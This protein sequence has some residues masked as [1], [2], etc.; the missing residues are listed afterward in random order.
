MMRARH[1][2]LSFSVTLA[3]CGSDRFLLDS[4]DPGVDV[5]TDPGFDVSRDN[6]SDAVDVTDAGN[7]SGLDLVDVAMD[8]GT[9]VLDVATDVSDVRVDAVGDAGP[10][11][12]CLPVIDGV[13]GSDWTASA[14]VAD[15]TVAT[16]WGVGM[17]DLRS[18]RVCYDST[19]LYLGIDGDAQ[20][21]N[22]VVAYIDRDYNPPGGAPTGVSIFSALTDH[23][24]ALDTRISAALMLGAGAGNFGAEA[25][26]GTNG[27]LSLAGTAVSDNAGLRLISQ[28]TS[29]LPDGGALPD[30]RADFAWTMGA[31]SA[32]TTTAPFAC[33]VSIA[34]AS[35]YEGPRPASGRIALFLRINNSD[36]T[37]TSNQTIPQDDPTMPRVVNRVLV[38]SFAP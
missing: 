6:G 26:W 14:I 25:A 16:A 18:L 23:A 24:G 32:C 38:L 37:M 10:S 30:R 9:D 36:G 33:E 12:R 2:L 7:D 1:L 11:G 34:W 31:Q 35:L 27:M 19:A 8:A 22:A 3:A 28:T 4:G 13:I 17:N 15:N 20:S 21:T 5:A 29:T